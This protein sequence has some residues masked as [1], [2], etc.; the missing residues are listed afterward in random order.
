M[1]TA[2]LISYF[3]NGL[4]VALGP[5]LPWVRAMRTLPAR[6][7]AKRQASA[8]RNTSKISVCYLT[9]QFPNRP[10]LRTEIAHG[11]EVKMTFLSETF[12]HSYPQSSLLYVVSS[13]DHIAKINIIQIAKQN[14]LKIILNQNGIAYQA[15]HGKGWE[16]PN[17]KM[18]MVYEQ[19]DFIVFQSEFCRLGAEKF[20][21]KCTTPYRVIYNPIDLDLYHPLNKPIQHRAPIL[22]LGGNQ[23]VPYRLEVAAQVLQKLNKYFP[24]SRLIVTGKLWGDNQTISMQQAV[25]LLHKL[26]ISE[27]VE[28]TGPYSQTDAVEIFQHAD[29]LIHTQYNDASPTLVGEAL[30]CGLPIVY[31][32]SGGTPELIGT[33]AGIG[34]PVEK[35]WEK[36]NTPDP[37]KMAEAVLK[38]WEKH[39]EFRES[40]RQFAQKQF[41]L[42]NY[43]QAH[44]EIFM[45]LL[46][47]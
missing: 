12:A 47:N 41:S 18:Q 29:I 38:V 8:L 30:A 22:L 3:K 42:K 2:L 7:R 13:V 32:S 28:F 40:A 36:I 45:Y 33:Q 4:R 27:K 11:G 21:G 39:N 35:S 5:M 25:L 34:I 10:A 37:E 23:L 43:I 9:R 16:E 14:G 26:G 46:E 1:R 31:S 20:L 44:Q 24:S 19:A 15:W 6:L 17:R